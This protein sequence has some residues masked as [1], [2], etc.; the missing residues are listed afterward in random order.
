MS[1]LLL[2]RKAGI[3]NLTGDG[4]LKLSEGAAMR[5]SRP[6]MVPYKY[7]R[8]LASALW[9]L[10]LPRAEAPPGQIDFSRYPW[11]ASNE[12]AESRARLDAAN[13]PRDVRGAMRA[14][15][16]LAPSSAGAPAAEIVTP[17]A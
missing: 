2:E 1:R 5:A 10:R 14:K 12:K 7:Y 16:K 15:G 8:R 9:R 17:V 6:A 3:F 4:T 11:L 13:E